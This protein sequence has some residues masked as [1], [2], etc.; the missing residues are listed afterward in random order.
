MKLGIISHSNCI[1]YIDNTINYLKFNNVEI[2]HCEYNSY[3]QLLNLISSAQDEMD[4]LLFAGENIYKFALSKVPSKIPW[5]FIDRNE[6]SVLKAFLEATKKG[7]DITKISIDTCSPER[8]NYLLM[9]Y[10]DIGVSDSDLSIQTVENSISNNDF[11]SKSH[12]NRI[13]NTHERL[14]KEGAVSCCL[15]YLENVYSKLIENNIPS[16]IF[17]FTIDAIDEKVKKLKLLNSY[18][19]S[20]NNQIVVLSMEIDSPHEKSIVNQD[21]YYLASEKIKVVE[22]VYIFAQK[23]KAAVIISDDFDRFTLFSTRKYVENETNNYKQINFLESVTYNTSFSVSIGIGYG[24]N[25]MDAK[26]NASFGRKH[27]KKN[28]GDRA[29]VVYE[30]DKILGPIFESKQTEEDREIIDF[31]IN[32]ISMNSG[33]SKKCILKLMKLKNQYNLDV[34]TSNELANYYDSTLRGMNKIINKLEDSGYVKVV[35]K[36]RLNDVGRPSR[37]LKLLF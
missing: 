14:Y 36:K 8:Y 25:A 33:L 15:T 2:N 27:A 17:D 20:K 35:G 5:E 9:A 6:S 7:Y 13:Y 31:K 1:N 26:K 29:F 32:E 23:I 18:T 28:G 24:S 34:V 22:Q 37:L 10:K 19:I 3:D 12:V 11:L 4:A 30:N 21:T 16:I